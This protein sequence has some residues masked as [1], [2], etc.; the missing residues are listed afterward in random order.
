MMFFFTGGT[1]VEVP[2][3]SAYGQRIQ[4]DR[5]DPIELVTQPQLKKTKQN[6]AQI[7]YIF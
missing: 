4:Y 5:R 1:I 3:K 6:H 2:V 7:K